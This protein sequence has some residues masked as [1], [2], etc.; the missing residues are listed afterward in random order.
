VDGT[1]LRV[2][3]SPENRAHFGSHTAG[4]DRDGKDRGPSGDPLAKVVTVMALRS[5]LLAAA[6]FGPHTTDE[7]QYAKALWSSIPER[8]LVL[9]DREYLDAGVLQG[10]SSTNR[11][12]LTPARSNSTWRV[13]KNLGKDDQLVEMAVSSEA[14]RKHPNLPTH[15]DARAIRY[16]RKGYPPRVLL[17]SL[18]DAAQY[19]ASELRVLYHERWEIEL[20]F[21]E[22]KTD[23]SRQRSRSALASAHWVAVRSKS[24]S[25]G[26][27]PNRARAWAIELG[28]TV[29]MPSSVGIARSSWRATSVIERSRMSAIPITSHTTCSAG[30]RRFRSV[31][32]PVVLSASSIQAGSKRWRNVV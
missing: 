21:D 32:V 23:M 4:A 16:Q 25:I 10:L 3:D 26:S 30:K 18:V 7:R 19:P 28:A 8:S 15:F 22:L 11:H 27:T 31:A 12:W 24:H 9:L 29:R 1:T 13:I 14:R 17:T 5:H 6:C 2:P 20:G